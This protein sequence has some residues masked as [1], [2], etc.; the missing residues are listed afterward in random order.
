M[1]IIEIK[2]IVRKDTPIYYRRF[3]TGIAVIELIDKNIEA[4]LE[5]QVEHMPTGQIEISILKLENIDYPRV[6]LHKELKTYIGALDSDG[7]L[8]AT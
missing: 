4:P 3:Y 8:P 1:K 5:F 2:N 6:P 7:K